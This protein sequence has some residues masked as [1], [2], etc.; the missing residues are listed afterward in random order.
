MW[1][2]KDQLWPLTHWETPGIPFPSLGLSFLICKMG[3]GD[4]VLHVCPKNPAPLQEDA[5]DSSRLGIVS[6]VFPS[7]SLEE[8][9]V[10]IPV[11]AFVLVG[12]SASQDGC[13]EP[14]RGS[15]I[16]PDT[17]PRPLPW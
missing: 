9:R 10:G 12:V 6:G 8:A 4:R 17:F 11:G 13:R 3:G 1:E 2:F 14:L 16:A 7:G 15:I 5:A